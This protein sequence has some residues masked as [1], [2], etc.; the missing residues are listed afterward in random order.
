MRVRVRVSITGPP[1]ELTLTA[2][3]GVRVDE[4]TLTRL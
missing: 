4:L 1:L 2:R 3:S